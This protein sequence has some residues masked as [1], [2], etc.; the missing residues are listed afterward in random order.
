MTVGDAHRNVN[1]RTTRRRQLTNGDFGYNTPAANYHLRAILGTAADAVDCEANR[2]Q[3]RARVGMYRIGQGRHAAIA[4][5]PHITAGTCQVAECHLV[6]I[7]L[8]AEVGNTGTCGTAP[9]NDDF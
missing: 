2:I 6:A 5:R 7:A 8:V 4:H 1:N 3:T 9:Y